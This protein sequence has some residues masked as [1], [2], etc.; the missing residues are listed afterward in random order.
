MMLMA[1]VH[2]HPRVFWPLLAAA[3]ALLAGGLFFLLA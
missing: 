3:V 2:R 1:V